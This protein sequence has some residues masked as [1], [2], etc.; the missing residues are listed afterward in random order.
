MKRQIVRFSPHQNAKVLAILMA[1]FTLVVFLPFLLFSFAAMPSTTP[2]G[3][4]LHFPYLMFLVMPLVY[5]VLT[6]IF[7]AIGCAIYNW[8]A[9]H[10]G[11][12]EFQASALN[13]NRSEADA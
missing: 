13:E 2:E 4:P 12:I 10:V 7:A 6:Y 3:K 1:L 8:L 9:K 5:L 11:G